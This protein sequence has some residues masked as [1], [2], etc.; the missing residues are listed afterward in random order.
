MNVKKHTKHQQSFI[1]IFLNE[2]IIMH[3]KI[4]ESIIVYLLEII[5]V[6]AMMYDITKHP[7]YG[8]VWIIPE[9]LP[10]YCV[11]IL[12][13]VISY[14]DPGSDDLRFDAYIQM[15]LADAS[16]IGYHLKYHSGIVL[17]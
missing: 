11:L 1:R 2:K 13:V 5:H 3:T 10:A 17:C 14:D 15:H 4:G 12:P 6:A 9:M 16:D 7:K 8:S